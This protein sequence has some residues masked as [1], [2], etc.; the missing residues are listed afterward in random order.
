MK[1]EKS[2]ADLRQDTHGKAH[3]DRLYRRFPVTI[4]PISLY[5]LKDLFLE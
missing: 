4:L 5:R 2:L 3:T 1:Y